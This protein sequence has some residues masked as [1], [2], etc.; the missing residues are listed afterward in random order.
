MIQ[1]EGHSET[2][3]GIVHKKALCALGQ[4]GYQLVTITEKFLGQEED[5]M[6]SLTI[7]S[8]M[9]IKLGVASKN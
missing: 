6:A 8:R 5:F 1:L 9:P 2:R 3:P 7:R 4:N